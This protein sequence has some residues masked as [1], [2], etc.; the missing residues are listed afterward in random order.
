M[1]ARYPS[2]MTPQDEATLQ[3]L[4]ARLIEPGDTPPQ[5]I[6]RTI[7]QMGKRTIPALVGL[8]TTGG[9]ESRWA[10]AKTLAEFHDSAA[11][12]G[13]MLALQDDD[14]GVRWVAAEGLI[15]LGRHAVD[16]LLKALIQHSESI[17][18]RWGA[19]HVLRSLSGRPDFKVLQPVVEALAGDQADLTVPVAAQ[20][21]L[22]LLDEQ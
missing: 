15:F 11:V 18:L 16:A 2:S 17:Y 8:L 21:A 19:N 3:S 9:I 20:R 22:A 4:M 6:R 5:E 10:A 12:P 7:I 13:L 1:A 14:S